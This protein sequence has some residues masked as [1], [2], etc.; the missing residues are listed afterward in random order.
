MMM[1]NVCA[2]MRKNQKSLVKTSATVMVTKTKTVATNVLRNPNGILF[3]NNANAKMK[4]IRTQRDSGVQIRTCASVTVGKMTMTIATVVQI[5]LTMIMMIILK[6]ANAL[7]NMNT[8][9]KKRRSVSVTG[10]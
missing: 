5:A 2:R 1:A 10:I 3:P 7:R 6:N 9:M 4:T 8:G